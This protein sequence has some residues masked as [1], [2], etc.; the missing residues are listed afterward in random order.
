MI[1]Q[2]V[3]IVVEAGQTLTYDLVGRANAAPMSGVSTAIR[4]AFKGLLD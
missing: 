3:G 4:S 2:S 1:E